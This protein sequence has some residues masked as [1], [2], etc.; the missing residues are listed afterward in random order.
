M[1]LA[2]VLA[3]AGVAAAVP[4][5][6]KL[7]AVG[8]LLRETA[9]I[10]LLYGLWQLAGHLSLHD[11]GNAYA[12][13]DTIRHWE[14]FLPL[15][16]EEAVQH[17]FLHWHWFIQAAN[18]YYATMH[19]TMLFVFLLWLF[20]RHRDRYRPIRQVLAWTTLGCLLVQLVPVAPPRMRPGIVDT[21]MQYGQSVYS[22]GLAAD[23]LSAMPSVHVA[24]AVLV[25]WYTW[26]VATS[27]WRVLGPI[28]SVV[29]IF[30]VVLTGNHWWSDGIVA[31]TILVICAWAV[32]GVRHAWHV[33]RSRSVPAT[34]SDGVPEPVASS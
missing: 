30:V 33:L 8:A 20:L 28:H 9:I 21:A 1:E 4:D 32:R 25:G 24:W 13:A 16:S 14:R 23:Q 15:P 10:G 19:F 12:R 27:R 34:A 22:N 6:P 17:A 11:T 26:H 3:A 31:V 5:R 18:L 7:R 29:T 2:A